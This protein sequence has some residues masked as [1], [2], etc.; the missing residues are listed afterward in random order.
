MFTGASIWVPYTFAKRD[1]TESFYLLFLNLPFFFLFGVLLWLSEEAPKLY[2]GEWE[3]TGIWETDDLRTQFAHSVTSITLSS[4][5]TN[6][7]E[8]KLYIAL[9]NCGRLQFFKGKSG[10]STSGDQAQGNDMQCE[11]I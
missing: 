7:C 6:I 9:S 10:S 2:C 4:M 11:A 1:C 3:F 8:K 5:Q